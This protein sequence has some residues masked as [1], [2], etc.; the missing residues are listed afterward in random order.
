MGKVGIL[1][2]TFDPIHNGH[3]AMAQIAREKMSLDEVIFV[4]SYLPPHKS[5]KNVVL[6]A[7]R[8]NMVILAIKGN[9]FFRISDY[10]VKKAGKSY[11][12]DTLRYFRKKMKGLKL[13]FI[14]GND[15]YEGLSQWKDID[16]ILKIA[17]FVVVNRPGSSR[18]GGNIKC[19]HVMMPGIEISSSYVRQRLEEGKEVRYWVPGPVA[20]YIKKNRLYQKHN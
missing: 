8:L 14:V 13:Y 11:S 2:G 17:H 1:G 3:L 19:H 16:E 6:A 5:P 20:E 9:P 4:P 12:I 15:A 10:E 18:K 7:D